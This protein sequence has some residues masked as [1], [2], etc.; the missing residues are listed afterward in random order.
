MAGFLERVKSLPTLGLGVSTEYG[1]G[2]KAGSLDLR[3][4]RNRFPQYGAFL[5]VGVETAVGLDA[6]AR[7]WVSSGAPTTYHFLDVNLDEP[8]DFDG[9]WLA[10]L[11]SFVKTLRPAWVCGD[12][13]LWHFGRRDRGQMLL[14]PP[15]LTSAVAE[16]MAPGVVRLRE[17]LGREVLPENP[18]GAVYLGDRHLLSFFGELCERADTGMVLDVAHLAIYQ[19]YAGLDALAGFGDFPIDR[20]VELHVAGGKRRTT[21]GYGWIEDDHGLEILPETWRIVEHVVARAPNLK[22]IVFECERNRLHDLLPAMGRMQRLWAERARHVGEPFGAPEVR[23]G[24]AMSLDAARDLQHQLVERLFAPGLD[25]PVPAALA[26]VDARAFRTDPLRQRRLV[27]SLLEEY[28]ASIAVV[29]LPA[30]DTFFASP[31]WRACIRERGSLG[32]TFG[33][34]VTGHAGA[35][36]RLEL[37]VARARRARAASRRDGRLR[38]PAT[39]ELLVLPHGAYSAWEALHAAHGPALPERVAAGLRA[40]RPEEGEASEWIFVRVNAQGCAVEALP[41]AVG[42]LLASVGDGGTRAAVVAEAVALG[43]PLDEA[44]DIVDGLLADGLLVLD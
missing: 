5:E 40:R 10:E 35:L 22:A 3:A 14:L 4:L 16:A 30:V 11:R 41:D 1:A 21:D 36:A 24:K 9:P 27:G 34:W 2:D 8:D 29:G 32:L 13:G 42:E 19:A 39:A 33:E 18:P 6:H 20:V 44:G 15:V 7:E 26:D 37:T 43:A 38:L 17:E 31:E 12:A 23:R 28:P 25:A